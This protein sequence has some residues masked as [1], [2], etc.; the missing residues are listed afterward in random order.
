LAGRSTKYLVH[1]A[2]AGGVL[3]PRVVAHGLHRGATGAL[4]HLVVDMLLH[5]AGRRAVAHRVLEGVGVVEIRLGASDSF[6]ELRVRLAGKPTMRSVVNV[7]P[8][9][10]SARRETSRYCAR[11]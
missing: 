8:G 9:S 6:L 2:Y 5:S 7:R 4:T 10:P 1:L 11:E 3:A